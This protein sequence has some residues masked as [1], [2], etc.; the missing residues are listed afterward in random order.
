MSGFTAAN[1]PAHASQAGSMWGAQQTMQTDPSQGLGAWLRSEASALPMELRHGL[2]QL[3]LC[4]HAVQHAAQLSFFLNSFQRLFPAVPITDCTSL[5]YFLCLDAA[6]QHSTPGTTHTTPNRMAATTYMAPHAAAAAAAAPTPGQTIYL[7]TFARQH[8]EKGFGF[9]ESDDFPQGDVFVHRTEADHLMIGQRVQF[10]AVL[11]EK[12]QY[13]ARDTQAATPEAELAHAAGQPGYG[14]A[15]A[16]A[17][18]GPAAAAQAAY[19]AS[20]T[21]TA[22]PSMKRK[23]TDAGIDPGPFTGQVSRVHPNG[24]GFIRGTQ[25]QSK[26]GHDAFCMKSD[27]ATLQAVAQQRGNDVIG[28]DVQFQV[29]VK[30]D[31]TIAAHNVTAL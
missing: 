3:M 30:D 6:A 12:G 2:R 24:F 21:P 11:N 13:Q 15:G 22:E 23:R 9:I 7:G 28:L 26:Y 20:H 4:P 25:I 1:T 5:D 8:P 18:G 16:A 31:G 29:I 14:Q 10:H 19:G 17:Y 27:I